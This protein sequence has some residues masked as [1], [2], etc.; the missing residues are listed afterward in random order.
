MNLYLGNLTE[1]N[2]MVAGMSK[3]ELLKKLDQREGMLQLCGLHLPV[4]GALG[5]HKD[6]SQG[7]RKSPFFFQPG[8]EV[9]RIIE[10]R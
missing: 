4:V 8:R 10:F 7:V 3:Q 5:L 9:P 2:K 1:I 6:K